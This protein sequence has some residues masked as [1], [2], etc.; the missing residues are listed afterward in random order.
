MPNLSFADSTIAFYDAKYFYQL[1]RPVTAIR[2]TDPTWTPQAA[3]A[4]DPLY[5][6]AHGVISGDGAAVLSAFFGNQDHISLTSAVLPGG[7]RTF[8]SYSD[9]ATEAGLS[10][11]YAGQHTRIDIQA[12]SQLGQ[13]VAQ[14]VISDL[15]LE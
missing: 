9:V 11:I 12:G 3:T 6:S 7:V 13:N 4:L 8:T 10:R 5:P 1:W 15:G 2:Q 14:F